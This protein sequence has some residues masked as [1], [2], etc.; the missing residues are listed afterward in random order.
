MT[1][2][3]PSP[4]VKGTYA[5]NDL[6]TPILVR[7]YEQRIALKLKKIGKYEA[8]LGLSGR[9]KRVQNYSLIFLRLGSLNAESK[10][11]LPDAAVTDRSY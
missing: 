11:L 5:T 4:L 6:P 3:H 9:P 7:M 8:R 10:R 1:T 2:T